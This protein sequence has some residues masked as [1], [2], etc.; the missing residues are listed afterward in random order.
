MPPPARSCAQF[1]QTLARQ[2][3]LD[4]DQS[5]RTVR[6]AWQRLE[7]WAGWPR[8]APRC[9]L[10]P[11]LAWQQQLR[12]MQRQLWWPA[13]TGEC[14]RHRL[15][16]RAAACR[17]PPARPHPSSGILTSQ[18]PTMCRWQAVRGYAADAA[19]GSDAAGPSGSRPARRRRSRR[20]G[21]RGGRQGARHVHGEP[22]RGRQVCRAGG[23][24]VGP[25]GALCAAARHEPGAL[26]VPAPRAVL[27]VW[28]RRARRRAA[29]RPAPA[30]RRLWRRA[31]GGEPG[32]HGCARHGRGR[33][34]GGAGHRRGAR[35]ARPGAGRAP[36]L[37]RRH[38]G[39]AGGGG[40]GVRRR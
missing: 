34:R 25:R 23:G 1:D 8:R 31:A 19:G 28:A 26:R 10:P 11:A 36:D 17:P 21:A 18:C 30:G 37:P 12:S 33:E 32:A 13:C 38:G 20:V 15:P 14:R 35:G 16:L 2:P 39:A 40:R 6:P 29:G 24:V 27:R 4:F 7:R 9:S 22:A 5:T 3:R